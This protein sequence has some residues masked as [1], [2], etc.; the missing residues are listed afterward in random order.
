MLDRHWFVVARLQPPH[1]RYMLAERK[2]ERH[3]LGRRGRADN[4]RQP[5]HAG[6]HAARTHV[7]AKGCQARQWLFN[8]LC[9]HGPRA[10]AADKQALIDQALHRLTHAGA[11]DSDVIAELPLARQCRAMLPHTILSGAAERRSEVAVD[12]CRRQT[13]LNGP[14]Q[15]GNE[16]LNAQAKIP[17]F[18]NMRIEPQGS[19]SVNSCRNCKHGPE[20]RLTADFVLTD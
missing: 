15:K 4:P 11:R 2:I 10:L 9:N 5:N 13:V 6:P 16:V 14:L 1:P 3:G 19:A 18:E 17:G 7:F 8:A 20:V 12:N